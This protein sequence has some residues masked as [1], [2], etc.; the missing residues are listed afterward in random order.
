[1]SLTDDDEPGC[2]KELLIVPGGVLFLQDVTQSVVLPQP[3]GGVHAE[4]RHKTKYLITNGQTL[5]WRYTFRV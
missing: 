3:Y 5:L 1:M 2:L 4:T